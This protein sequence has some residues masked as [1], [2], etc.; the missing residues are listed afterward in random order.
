[1]FLHELPSRFVVELVASGEDQISELI[2]HTK[3]LVVG[4]GNGG[5]QFARLKMIEIVFSSGL[6]F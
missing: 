3:L 5:Q 4:L 1:M 2:R 6:N